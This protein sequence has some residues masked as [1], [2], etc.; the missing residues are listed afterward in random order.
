MS[1]NFYDVNFNQNIEGN[2]I[3]AIPTISGYIINDYAY[4]NRA[5]LN[6]II[7][8][9]YIVSNAQATNSLLGA[10][11]M[12]RKH[13]T[14]QAG[15][16]VVCRLQP[17][18]TDC[19]YV[20][21]TS[22]GPINVI[23]CDNTGVIIETLVLP[24]VENYSNLSLVGHFDENDELDW[25]TVGYKYK[26][27]NTNEYVLL[28]N[29]YG[30]S[31]TIKDEL[32]PYVYLKYKYP[33]QVVIQQSLSDSN[34]F[35][36]SKF[37]DSWYG[38]QVYNNSGS[39]HQQFG[40][41]VC[42]ISSDN[43]YISWCGWSRRNAP[44]GTPTYYQNI[45]QFNIS[46]KFGQFMNSF[47][48]GS[49]MTRKTASGGFYN[50]LDLS[51]DT[52]AW[53]G[54]TDPT[55]EPYDIIFSGGKIRFKA[56]LSRQIQLLDE[57]DNLID[58]YTM[59][60]PASGGGSSI[61]T[62]QVTTPA[63][64][65]LMQCYLSEK[66]NKFYLFGLLQNQILYDEND[67]RCEINWEGVGTFDQIFAYVKLHE[68]NND[69]NTLLNRA[70]NDVI[71]KPVNPDELTGDDISNQDTNPEY[72]TD[73]GEYI[74][75]PKKPTG[76]WDDDSKDGIRGTGEG[77][78]IG[79][80]S[81]KA[82][83]E[84]P[85]LPETPDIP[86]SVST[87]FMKLYNPTTTEIQNLC[88]ELTDNSILETLKKYFGNNPLD[89]IVG[90]H[91]VPGAYTTDNTK[92][93][94]K[95]GSYESSVA[96]SPITDEFCTM[97]YGTLDLKEI[98]GN[99]EDYNPHTK[100]C[101]YLP[102]IGIRDIDTDKVNGTTLKLKYH[103]DAVTGSILAVL[104]STRMDSF[105]PGAE[106]IVGQWT[107]QASYTIPLTNVQHN[108]AV[109][110]VIGVVSA[111]ISI[112]AGIATGGVSTLASV[113]TVGMIGS[114]MLSG[115]KSGKT[116]ITMQGGVS[117]SLSFFTG[118]DAYIQISYPREGRPDEYNHIV[119]QP[120]NLTTDI[121]HQPKDI[122]IEF[123][124]VDISGIDAPKDEKQ[125]ILDLLKGGVY[126]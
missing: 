34:D 21:F 39:P 107:G 96:M 57:N 20:E 66:N 13:I 86:S 87:G 101:I 10:I 121:K 58:S 36:L 99:W 3:S 9:N 92:Y 29:T 94:I 31:S 47:V 100:M 26:D 64:N 22:A 80:S 25:V 75:V 97:D 90:L 91:V 54:T 111:G 35:A 113:G 42:P 28:I 69:A 48:L 95:Y 106:Y 67:E 125:M 104:T 114:T 19:I 16:I 60:Y 120:S 77:Q 71:I 50:G 82:L 62:G 23:I 73:D 89:F 88:I 7:P 126:T 108:N 78:E 116:D 33:Y 74:P 41:I 76:E 4:Q 84:Q 85:D 79:E 105:N 32:K 118:K 55:T 17:D 93:I 11:S 49:D 70:T 110:A 112:G 56:G 24:Y 18:G 119:G 27:E 5:E 124:N 43:D 109:N 122:Y 117:G 83:D 68:F 98:Y 30:F 59:P 1:V 8:E 53:H 52:L 102:Y 37:P 63:Y 14:T 2:G 81:E 46:L 61:Y 123:V 6:G 51:N 72:K 12:D 65:S 45:N 44:V 38:K 103:I 15:E 40:E 115:A